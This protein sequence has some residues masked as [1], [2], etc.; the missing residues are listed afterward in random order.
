M[1]NKEFIKSVSLPDEEWRDVVGYEGLYM[2]SSFGRIASLEH[3]VW[4][5]PNGE[6]VR[7]IPQKIKVP[8]IQKK[9]GNYRIATVALY[10]DHRKYERRLVHRLVAL[11]FIPNPNDYPDI[12][13]I[14][15]NPIN[16]NVNNLRWASKKMNQNNPISKM[17]MSLAKIG[18]DNA[19][20]R[21][22]I[23]KMLNN[24]PIKFYKGLY[25]AVKDGFRQSGI[26]AVLT[27]KY[28]SSGGF[29]WMYLS[30]YEALIKSKNEAIPTD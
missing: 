4:N 18:V 2:V 8:S 22:P 9:A 28:K 5:R 17:R 7:M 13:H 10:K 11:S 19:H 21:K 16:N 30:D 1:T 25:E 3:Q 15:G 14:D 24:K 20:L 27:G 6:S 26:S 12:D 23:V 29:Q